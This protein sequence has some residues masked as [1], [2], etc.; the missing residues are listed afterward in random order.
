MRDYINSRVKFREYFRPFA[1]AVL[2]E[3]KNKYFIINQNSEHMLI[4]TKT[5]KLAKK[6]I[7]ATV[8]VDGTS[9]VQTVNQGLLIINFGN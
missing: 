5:N 3:K 7:P 9:R 8:H 6:D 2:E 1:P 4:A